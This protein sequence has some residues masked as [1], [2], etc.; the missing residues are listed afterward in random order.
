MNVLGNRHVGNNVRI[1][2]INNGRGTEFRNY[3]NAGALFGESTDNY[4]AAAGHYGKQSRNLVRHYAEDLGFRYLSAAN[5]EE[6]QAAKDEFLS[7]NIGNS[8]ILFECFTNSE[9]E[10]NALKSIRNI[11]E[12]PEPSMM[13]KAKTMVASVVGEKGIN[14]INKLRGK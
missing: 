12:E 9:D 14:A 13:Q 6:F 3:D 10:S 5:K 1:L 2:L 8:P 11:I 4:I 7:T